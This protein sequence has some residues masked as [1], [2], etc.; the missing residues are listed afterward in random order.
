MLKV[1]VFKFYGEKD[2]K[3]LFDVLIEE[4]LSKIKTD[5]NMDESTRY[6]K[7]NYLS[8]NKTIEVDND[9]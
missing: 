8:T 9:E 6:N 7:D 2:F 5:I 4:K 1:N 3:E